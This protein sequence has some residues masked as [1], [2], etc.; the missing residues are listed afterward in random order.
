[1]LGFPTTY[2]ISKDGK[3]QKKFIG[4]IPGKQKQLTQGIDTLLN[5]PAQST[6]PGSKASG[7][8]TQAEKP[9]GSDAP[10]QD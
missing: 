7:P 5:T 8:V 3:I 2:L 10:S 9:S 1:M 6:Q 4:S